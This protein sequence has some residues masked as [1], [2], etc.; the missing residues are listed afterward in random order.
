VTIVWL[1]VLDY[2]I[3]LLC[4]PLLTVVLVLD[5]VMS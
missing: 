3:G 2:A 4:L 1:D 5:L